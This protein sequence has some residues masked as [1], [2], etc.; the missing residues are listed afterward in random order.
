MKNASFEIVIKIMLYYQELKEKRVKIVQ[1]SL[2]TISIQQKC[3]LFCV[4]VVLSLT[5]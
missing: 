4:L 3:F 2:Y 5:D 1:S